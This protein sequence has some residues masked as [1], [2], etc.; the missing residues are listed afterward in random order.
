VAGGGGAGA[1]G[2]G[3]GGPGGR[4]PGGGEPGGGGRGGGDPG[5]GRPA[6]AA[7]AAR[8]DPPLDELAL[9]I[10]VE[11]RGIDAAAVRGARARLDA[12]G[13]ELAEAAAGA[14]DPHAEARACAELLGERHGFAGDAEHYDDPAN[15]MLDLVLSRRRGLPILLS[16]VYV[17][18]ARRAGVALAGVGLPG[19]YVVGH[20]GASPP[21]LLDPFAGGA[22][23]AGAPPPAF[24]RPWGAHETALRI[25]NNLV[26]SYQRRGNVGAA[27]AAARMRLDLP[28]ERPLRDGLETEL[29]TLQ[30][31]LN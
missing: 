8:P 13:A 19:H 5:G 12:L 3:G 24:V 17:A 27:I 9:G 26:G 22:P 7:L 16:V 25:L 14:S 28:L 18:V 10:A 20:F 15:S 11:L 29:R 23:V 4:G 30:A 31:R 21:L 6:F 1:G 2:P